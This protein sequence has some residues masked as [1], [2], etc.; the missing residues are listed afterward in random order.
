MIL[1]PSESPILLGSLREGDNRLAE[2]ETRLYSKKTTSG[3]DWQTLTSGHLVDFLLRHAETLKCVELDHM[4]LAEGKWPECFSKFA[5]K[6]PKL[7][8]LEVRGDF[9]H[10][11]GEKV[12][13]NSTALE[14]DPSNKKSTEE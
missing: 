8:L 9:W 3:L 11:W 4:H 7:H 5:G 6:L 13:G 14:N 12:I 10:E 2:A 1:A